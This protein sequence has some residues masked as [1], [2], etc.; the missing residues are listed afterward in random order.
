MVKHQGFSLIELIVVIG[1]LSLLTLA[2][3]SIML[4]SILSSNRVRLTT[5]IKQSGN[6]ALG[7]IQNMIRNAKSLETCNSVDS[8]LI[9]TNQDGGSTAVVMEIDAGGIN[10]VASNSGIYL[11]P[12]TI[13]VST[14]SINCEPSDETPALIKISFDLHTANKSISRQNPSLHFETSINLR[15]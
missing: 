3:S 6:Y 7:Q 14:F 15:N 5:K 2:I 8:E 1:L 4:T 11:T 12:E 10:R 9:L 13:N